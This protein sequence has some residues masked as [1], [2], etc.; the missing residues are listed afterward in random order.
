LL[1]CAEQTKKKKRKKKKMKKEA[2]HSE[3]EKRQRASESGSSLGD[4]YPLFREETGAKE[5]PFRFSLPCSACA[6]QRHL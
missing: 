5:G 2:S 1:D 4:P 3:G 6:F